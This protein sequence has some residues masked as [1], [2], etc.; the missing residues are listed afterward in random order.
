MGSFFWAIASKTLLEIITVDDQNFGK[1]QGV[2]IDGIQRKLSKS[3]LKDLSQ[4]VNLEYAT[5]P[6]LV[7]LA[8]DERCVK[9]SPVEGCSGLYLMD[10]TGYDGG[11]GDEPIQVDASAIV[12]DG[13]HR[14]AG[15]KDRDSKKRAFEVNVS[16]FIEVD[17]LDQA[18]IFS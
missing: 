10:V 8:I 14:L 15:L 13:Q 16:I 11:E 17:I 4:Y 6:T 5:F 18:E 2:T 9:L 1:G 7:I 12:I 3:R